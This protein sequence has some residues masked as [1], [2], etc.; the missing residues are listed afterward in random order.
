MSYNINQNTDKTT[1]LQMLSDIGILLLKVLLRFVIKAGRLLWQLLKLTGKLLAALINQA[2]IYWNSTG[3]KEKRRKF[4]QLSATFLKAIG[5][6][7]VWCALQLWKGIVWVA[8][9]IWHGII[10]V[11]KATVTAI[12]HLKP[13]LVRF[14]QYCKTQWGKCKQ[15]YAEYKQNGGLKGSLDAT[16]KQLHKQ[17][18]LYMDEDESNAKFIITNN[19]KEDDT[20][21]IGDAEFI[22]E[23]IGQENKPRVIVSHIYDTLKRLSG[24]E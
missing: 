22:S 16:K 14:G 24:N 17:L 3:T 1:V 19:Q 8:V 10:W 23:E 13:T 7:L 15:A 11:A 21:P 6:G 4:V 9:H 20:P 2:V 18:E 12:I 5:A